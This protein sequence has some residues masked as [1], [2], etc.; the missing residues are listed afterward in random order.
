MTLEEVWEAKHCIFSRKKM[1]QTCLSIASFLDLLSTCTV[2][3]MCHLQ[4][5]R[6]GKGTQFNSEK[7][8][9][10]RKESCPGWDSNSQLYDL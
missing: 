6:Q 2:S 5:Y 1:A 10:Q 7:S 9:F 8:C 4:G 3:M